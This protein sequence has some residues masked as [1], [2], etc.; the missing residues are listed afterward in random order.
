MDR[1]AAVIQLVGAFRRY[2]Y[3][4]ASM[5]KLS[6]ATGLGKSSLYHHFPG[7]KEEMARAVLTYLGE[8]LEAMMLAP[9]RT[10]GAPRDRIQAMILE[11]DRFYQQGQLACPLILFAF[12]EAHDIFAE[13]VRQ[14]F[15]AWID[16][17]TAVVSEAGFTPAMARQRSEDAILQIQGAIVMAHG[18]G[19]NQPFRRILNNL[20][21]VLLGPWD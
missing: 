16:A 2:G 10:A 18:L 12:G 4:G 3:E 1:Q 21:D 19:N 5:A 7:G 13:P 14:N 20:P 11:V 6:E 15:I 9:L 8:G 17:L